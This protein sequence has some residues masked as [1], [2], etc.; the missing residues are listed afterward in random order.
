MT[1]IAILTGL[2]GIS[3][4]FSVVKADFTDDFESYSPGVALGSPWVVGGTFP[5]PMVVNDD[6]GYGSSQGVYGNDASW[7]ESDRTTNYDVMQAIHKLTWKARLSSVNG[8]ARLTAGAGNAVSYLLFEMDQNPAVMAIVWSGGSVAVVEDT[9]YTVSVTFTNDGGNWSWEGTY[10]AGGGAINPM[11]SGTLPA[12]WAPETVRLQGI[13]AWDEGPE[14]VSSIDDVSFEAILPLTCSEVLEQEPRIL[15]DINQDC[16]VD[17]GDIAQM[18]QE[19][20]RCIDPF[21]PACEKPWS[22]P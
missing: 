21:N 16:Y 2:I 6:S 7:H 13:W 12:G 14:A 19:W 17:I 9:W 22:V 1:R 5:N 18:A 8:L 15:G 10:Q 4:M 3:S 11:G 20:M